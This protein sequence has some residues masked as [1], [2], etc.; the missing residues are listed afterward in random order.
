MPTMDRFP[1]CLTVF[2]MPQVGPHCLRLPRPGSSMRPM[3][4]TPPL[5]PP[6]TTC[7]HLQGHP[8]HTLWHHVCQLRLTAPCLKC[9]VLL[10]QSLIIPWQASTASESVSRTTPP[11]FM[12]G[13][14]AQ[15]KNALPSKRN[16]VSIAGGGRGKEMRRRQAGS[17][18]AIMDIPHRHLQ[19]RTPS[20]SDRTA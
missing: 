11:S 6:C 12:T 20:S 7:V 3:L 14:S 16:L 1:H 18:H 13:L 19:T 2:D 17:R 10:L 15:I 9:D 5:C 4:R 8:L